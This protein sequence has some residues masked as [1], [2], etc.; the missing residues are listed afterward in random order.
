MSSHLDAFRDQVAGMDGTDFELELMTSPDNF[1]G[2]VIGLM[3]E[4]DP[5]FL[6]TEGDPTIS[7]RDVETQIY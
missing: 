7:G 4:D 2:K 6:P 5:D 1:V 3:I